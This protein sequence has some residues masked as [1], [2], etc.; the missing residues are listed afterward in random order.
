[1]STLLRHDHQAL[2]DSLLNGK[3]P[4]NL[5]WADVVDLI[6]KIGEVQPH[7]SDEFVFIVGAQRGFF[8]KPSSHDLDVEEVSRLRKFLKEAEINPGTPAPPAGRLVVVID[9]H[10]AHV[11]E[12]NNGAPDSEKNITPYDPHGFQHHLIHRKEAHYRGERA[13]EEQSFYEQVAKAIVHASEIVLIG[14]GT[15]NSSA[16]DYLAEYLK[17]HHPETFKK[18]VARKTADLSALTEPQLM[19]LAGEHL[20][21]KNSPA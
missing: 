17:T 10:A 3:L 13:P 11:Y 4:R 20:Q 1:M 5:P 15:G 6:S 16:A 12:K 7:G 21:S 8:K 19:A 2:L 14:H 9:H 18:I